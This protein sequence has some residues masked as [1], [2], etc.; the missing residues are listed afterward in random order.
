MRSSAPLWRQ[1][2]DL[3]AATQFLLPRLNMNTAAAAA[4]VA[5][6]CAGAYLETGF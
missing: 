3:P 4:A 5:C 2:T 6:D 1:A